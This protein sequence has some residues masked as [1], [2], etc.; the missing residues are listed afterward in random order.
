L[1]YSVYNGTEWSASINP[2]LSNP[3]N[4]ATC[5]MYQS[6]AAAVLNNQIFVV[7]QD[8]EA[9]GALWYTV[10]NGSSWSPIMQAG[11]AIQMS[12][13]TGNILSG[14]AASPESPFMNFMIS[15]FEITV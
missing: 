1:A 13:P 4:N 2:T 6:P 3:D 15:P 14:V 7:F 12:G 11:N 8:P 10:F 9:T 5:N